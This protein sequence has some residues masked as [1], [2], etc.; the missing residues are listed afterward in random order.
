M[1]ALI[2]TR[3]LNALRADL[4]KAEATIKAARVKGEQ[5]ELE[6][7]LANAATARAEA[8]AE[9]LQTKLTRANDELCLLKGELG[10]LRGQSLL[11]TEDRQALRMLL[12]T[13]RKQSNRA[14]HVYLLYRSGDLHSVHATRDAAQ[15]TAETE[16]AP[17]DG[18]AARAASRSPEPPPSEVPWLIW[19]V[20]LGGVR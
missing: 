12:R 19:P 11:D 8:T 1:I 18:W 17:Q 9:T 14:D 20:P 5:H 13:A 15:I 7:D 10:A 2:R 16:G 3:T 6:R 4:A